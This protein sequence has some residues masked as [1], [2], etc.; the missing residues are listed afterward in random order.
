MNK[1]NVNLNE[2]PPVYVCGRVSVMVYSF[3]NL[4]FI[5]L[6]IYCYQTPVLTFAQHVLSKG[7]TVYHPFVSAVIITVVAWIIQIATLSMTKLQGIAYSLTF[8]PSM[9][10]VALLT[11]VVP[12]GTEGVAMRNWTWATPIILLIYV[13]VV[14][15]MRQWSMVNAVSKQPYVVACCNLCISLVMMLC[16]SMAGNHDEMFHKR[17][18]AEKMMIDMEYGNIAANAFQGGGIMRSIGW[19]SIGDREEVRYEKTDTTLSLIRYIALG[20]MGLLPE[21]IFTQPFM[22]DRG[23]LC[24]MKN[25]KP[26]L[27]KKELLSRRRNADYYLCAFLAEGD[28]DRFAKGIK[29][30]W[31]GRD[32]LSC[33]SLPRHYREAMV[34]YQHHRSKPIV[35]CSDAVM[36]RDFADM[37]KIITDNADEKKRLFILRKTYGNTYWFYYYSKDLCATT[38][39]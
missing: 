27:F 1:K 22:G 10:A 17:I 30:I 15:I 6:Y 39:R 36:E 4:I 32:S 2:R 25:V 9:L 31:G 16:V 38:R 19:K 28:L 24:M 18:K 14:H 8:V 7:V 29:K 21:K 13:F 5:F 33:D 20:K 3:I 23:S 12:E 26:Y 11:A 35:K 34:L 37:R